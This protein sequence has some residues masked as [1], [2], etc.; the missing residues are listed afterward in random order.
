M[1]TS[2][3]QTPP[4]KMLSALRRRPLLTPVWLT[5]LLGIVL[6]AAGAWL[7]SSQTT[8]TIIVVRHAEKELGSIDDPPLSTAG[9]QRA[10]ALGR[11]FGEKSTA[12]QVDAIFAS[13]TRRGQRTAAPLALRL[14]ISVQVYPGREVQPLLDKIDSQYRGRRILVVGHSNTVPDLVR[15]LAPRANV[16]PMGEDDYDT[17]YVVTV[18]SLGPPAVLR[19]KY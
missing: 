10:A 19:V 4:R 13:D 17:M 9:E 15:R 16:P 18:P 12:G 11:M 1:A 14:G 3:E 8:T 2:P 5:L 6:V 7:W